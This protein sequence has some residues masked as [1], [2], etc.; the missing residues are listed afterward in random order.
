MTPRVVCVEG[1]S[2]VGKTSLAEAL[3]RECGAAV[4]P[5]LDTSDAPPVGRSAMWFADRSAARWQLA[6]RAAAAPF[7]VLDGDPFKGLWYNWIYAGDGWEDVGVVEPLYRSYIERGALA[8]PDLYVVLQAGE[9]ELRTRRAGDPTRQRR[10]LETHL[11]M[12]GPQRLY[13]EALRAA[14]PARV[15][16]VEPGPRSELVGRVMDALRRLP[17]ERPDSL[18][19]LEHAAGW[20][21][22]HPPVAER[23]GRERPGAG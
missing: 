2:A 18:G 5:E 17:A 19:L 9:D 13:F 14:A 23:A 16:I 1:P 4:V 21:R 10:H 8:F 7:A 22:A 3:A 6:A 11:R 12:V 20:I 15:A